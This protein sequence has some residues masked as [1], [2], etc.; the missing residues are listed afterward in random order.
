MAGGLVGEI[1][2]KP[3]SVLSEPELGLRLAILKHE[4]MEH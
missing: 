1:Q 4:N 3:N 2:I